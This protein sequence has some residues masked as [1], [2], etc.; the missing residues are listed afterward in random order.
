MPTRSFPMVG[1]M[2]GNMPSL[3]LI[4][5]R[6]RPATQTPVVVSGKGF[7]VTYQATGTYRIT[8]NRVVQIISTVAMANDA[9]SGITKVDVMGSYNVANTV[10]LVL[11]DSAGDIADI[12]DNVLVDFICAVMLNTSLPG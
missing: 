4:V 9:L 5:G 8:F 6:I 11:R 3:H 10:D 7:R 2:T 1:Q 12:G